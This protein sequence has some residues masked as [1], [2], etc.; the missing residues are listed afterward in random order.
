MAFLDLFCFFLK[1]FKK[2]PQ[3]L[4]DAAVTGSDRREWV[5]KKSKFFQKSPQV[6]EN[7]ADKQRD[8]RNFFQS[9][10]S[11]A[12]YSS[13]SF[14]PGCHRGATMIRAGLSDKLLRITS[15]FPD[16]KYSARPI[17][18]YLSSLQ[19]VSHRQYT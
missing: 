6:P 5:E 10:S 17:P 4:Q 12:Q 2:N 19:N 18:E 13:P 14:R 1:I 16:A 9:Q 8:E 7:P 11:K 3:V 15:P